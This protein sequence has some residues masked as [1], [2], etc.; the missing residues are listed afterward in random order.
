MATMMRSIQAQR[1]VARPTRSTRAARVV[2]RAA[3][4]D[5]TPSAG[6]ASP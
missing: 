2:P 3:D 4:K 6:N 1:L 5:V